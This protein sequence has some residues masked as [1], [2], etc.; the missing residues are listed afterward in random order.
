MKLNS[1]LLAFE[2]KVPAKVQ[3]DIE[4]ARAAISKEIADL[5]LITVS[6]TGDQLTAAFDAYAAD[7]T[8]GESALVLL[9]SDLGLPPPS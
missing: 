7:E 8:T 5:Q 9:R 1:Q 2:Q 4:T 3:R 6:T